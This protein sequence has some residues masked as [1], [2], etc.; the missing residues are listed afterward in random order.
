MSDDEQIETREVIE[1]LVNEEPVQETVI[2]EEVKP[3]KQKSKAKAKP[4]IKIT[5]EPVE[6]IIE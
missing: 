4:K 2:E 3:V 1:R 5:K 6:T